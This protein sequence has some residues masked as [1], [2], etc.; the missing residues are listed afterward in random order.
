MELRPQGIKVCVL[1]PGAIN[2]PAVEKTLGTVEKSISA[3][4]P[5]G[6]ALYAGAMRA[7]AS[8]FTKKEH[9]GSPPEAVAE[10]VERALTDS[11]PRTRYAAGKDATKLKLLGTFLPEKL[12]DAALLR[13]FGMPKAFLRP[14]Q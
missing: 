11:H 1:E 8:T 12:L 7:M 10:V 4:P 6:V 5:E 14:T 13:V 2:T 3:L 9:A